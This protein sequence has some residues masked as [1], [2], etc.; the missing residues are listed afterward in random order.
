VLGVL[1]SLA[2]VCQTVVVVDS[3]S[4]D[5]TSVIAEANRAVVWSRPFDSFS[6]QRNWALDQIATTFNPR[7]ILTLD[8]D[9]RLSDDLARELLQ[10]LSSDP[11]FEI[12]MIRRQLRFAGKYLRFGGFSRTR[13]PRLFRLRAGRYE[14]R[15]VNEHFIPTPG[16]RLGNLSH[17]LL[18]LDVASWE[19]YVAKHNLYSTLEAT[20]RYERFKTGQNLTFSSAI[21]EGWAV[22]DRPHLRRRWMREQVFNR[23]PA[24]GALRFFHIYLL[25]GGFLD[26]SAGFKAALFQSWQEMITDL[27]FKEL[28]RSELPQ[29]SKP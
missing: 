23:L 11:P 1:E 19:R 12:Y 2:A 8:A 21:S 27:K 3:F 26:G 5:N 17:P 25:L 13:L 20:A 6:G 14:D 24:K 16:A 18:H 29:S 4:A 9:E 7:W 10:V 28:K 22:R 15:D